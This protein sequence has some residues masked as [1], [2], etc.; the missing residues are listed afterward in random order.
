MNHAVNNEMTDA[1]L[2]D[3]IIQLLFEAVSKHQSDIESEK[4]WIMST[5]QNNALL[6]IAHDLTATAFH[7]LD[8][9]GR[10]QPINSIDITKKSG[11]PKGTVSKNIKKLTSKGLVT[12][13]SLPNNKKESMLNLTSSGEEIY[14][15]HSAFH[16]KFDSE[17]SVFLKQYDT[18]ELQFLIQFLKDFQNL[19]WISSINEVSNI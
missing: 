3:E 4:E 2:T 10:F 17:F 19:T 14:I 11:I 9:I 5:C 18:H 12:K 13:T 15:V 6:K 1:N 7:T 8:A 16:Q